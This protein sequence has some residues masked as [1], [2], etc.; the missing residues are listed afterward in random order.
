MTNQR[1]CV[2]CTKQIYPRGK[3][4]SWS[5]VHAGRGICMSCWQIANHHGQIPYDAPP[6][7]T[8]T[9][10]EL[11]DDYT[12]LRADGYT[13]RQ[14]AERLGMTYPAFERA[15]LRARKDGDLRAMRP[16]ENA[17]WAA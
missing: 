9:R 5:S 13:W 17:R 1:R 10:D 11:L 14:C 16:G 8:R 7:L 12:I 6:R 15:M 2:R 4:P 3:A